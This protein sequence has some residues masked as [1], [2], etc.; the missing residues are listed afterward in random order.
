ME[1]CE[2]ILYKVISDRNENTSLSLL[3]YLFEEQLIQPS[4]RTIENLCT[5]AEIR[6][7]SIV[8]YLH[9]YLAKDRTE[10]KMLHSIAFNLNTMELHQLFEIYHSK[11]I[12][13][14]NFYNKDNHNFRKD[15]EKQ[16]K[17]RMEN[18]NRYELLQVV[19]TNISSATGALFYFCTEPFND[20][21]SMLIFLLRELTTYQTLFKNIDIKNYKG[22]TLVKFAAKQSSFTIVRQLLQRGANL[23][24][25]NINGETAINIIIDDPYH[26]K[27]FD[28]IQ[29]FISHSDGISFAIKNSLRY[30]SQRYMG[31]DDGLEMLLQFSQGKIGD[32]TLKE[33]WENC[34][35]G[36]NN[37]SKLN[38]LFTHLST[39][40]ADRMLE[41]VKDKDFS[42]KASKCNL[43]T[44]F[45]RVK[46]FDLNRLKAT[47]PPLKE[48]A[49]D[50]KRK[51]Y[52][53]NES[54]LF[55]L[56][57]LENSPH[58]DRNLTNTRKN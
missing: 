42:A 22:D 13:E 48:L 18:I 8:A 10:Q 38:A 34:M 2:T 27:H 17:L 57:K 50:H 33:L 56:P 12:F 25:P 24:T 29:N 30:E 41:L 35:E 14:A 28:W 15:I 16:I 19:K 39:D 58:G 7:I 6:N 52:D 36:Y 45:K 31:G 9:S 43:E 5:K 20:D 44:Y 3:Q 46:G 32:L 21:S 49:P 1:F 54:V 4:L 47:E 11:F 55:K 23:D 40:Y 51:T 26:R 37:S 53:K